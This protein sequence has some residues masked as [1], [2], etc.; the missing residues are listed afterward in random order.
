M[1]KLFLLTAICGAAF[2]A[3]AQIPFPV[4]TTVDWDAKTITMP[5]SNLK[6]QPIFVGGTDT[7][8]T[9]STYGNAGG[10]TLAKEWHDFIG[11]VPD[12]TGGAIGWVI[13][14]HEMVTKDDMIGDGGGMT[15]F[16]IKRT[17][18][19]VLE[20]MEQTLP[21]GRKGKF[22]NVDFVNTV[23]ETGMNCGG[24]SA[25]HI[26]RIW[27]AEEWFQTSNA[28]I[29]SGGNGIRDTAD[30]T[31]TGTA[32]SNFN[33]KTI[34]KYQ[35]L[36][37]MVEV[38]AKE[39]KAIRKQ[40][41]WGRAGWEAGVV[42]P[43]NKTVYLF[44]DNT[45]GIFARFVATTAGDFTSGQL[46]V[47]KHDGTTSKW[48]NIEQ[49]LDTLMDLS[50][51]AVRRGATMFNRLEWG[52]LANGK[53]YITETG[54]SSVGTRFQNKGGVINPGLV[55]AYKTRYQVENGTAFTGTDADAADSVVAGKF[56]DYYG[57]VLEYDPATDGIRTYL[58]G[59]PFGGGAGTS[60]PKSSYPSKHLS[61][62]DGLS[63]IE[64]NGKDYLLIL[65]DM[66][67][68]DWNSMPDG[69]SAT[70]NEAWLLDASITN[71]T[72]SD[73]QRLTSSG[74]A[75]EVTG[76]VQLDHKTILID[77][78]HPDAST[79]EN[80]APYNHSLTFAISAI[81]GSFPV[82]VTNPAVKM[83]KFSVYPNPVARELHL[84]ETMDVAIY[85][86]NGQRMNVYRG[87]NTIDVSNMAAGTYFIRSAD[88]ETLKFIIE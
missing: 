12:T 25:K 58:E 8:I 65:E 44:E 31:I 56:K 61:N 42:M 35:N 84:S 5:V 15:T 76:G 70:R 87:V 27:T 4:N 57:R 80:A 54:R 50:R 51:V 88:G 20:V 3:H 85:N 69:Y 67:Q 17:A 74:N 64:A 78:Q 1:K 18:G 41:N 86:M 59:G 43:D 83:N 55:T 32:F 45:P 48:I 52:T 23:G 16:K 6:V 47:Y 34:K 7:V 30:F 75:A 82:G 13:V 62:P 60:D 68:T 72:V 53:I 63:T 39:G 10:K 37:W 29:Y 36:N 19:D 24:I 14:N 66:N 79:S 49:N 33:G 26:G 21:D 73:L 71:P 81:D 22:F 9:T 77:S 40:Y 38:N 11:V 46:A 28:G 2:S